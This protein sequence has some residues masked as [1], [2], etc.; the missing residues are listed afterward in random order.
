MTSI[1]ESIKAM[2]RLQ[3]ICAPKTFREH[4]SRI[5]LRYDSAFEDAW[6]LCYH[7]LEQLE[8]SEDEVKSINELRES[9]YKTTYSIT[10]NPEIAGLVSD[11]FELIGKAVLRDISLPWLNGLWIQYR[12]NL[13]PA[14]HINACDGTIS[15]LID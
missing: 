12:K 15:S 5:E 4:Q 7:N 14:G 2:I 13:F 11:D 10:D 3:K 8:L 1:I 9:A 6:M